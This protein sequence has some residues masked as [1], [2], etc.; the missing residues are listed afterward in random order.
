[1]P[2]PT[3]HHP[4]ARRLLPLLA[5]VT[6]I[7]AVAGCGARG[8][9]GITTL[10]F[11][12]AQD[13]GTFDRVV[14]AFEA[15]HPAIRIEQQAVPFDDL[16]ATLQSR[17]GTRDA[18]IDLYDVDEPRLAAFAA[19]GFLEPLDDLAGAAAGRIDPAALKITNYRGTQ[20]AMPRWT[21]SQL[22]YYNRA[23]LARAGITPPS[24][25]PQSPATW[26]RI[27]ADGQRA[28]AAGARYG[29]IFDQVDRYYQLQPLAASLGGGPGLTGPDLLEPDITNAAW[30][31]AFSWYHA[32]FRS[33]VAPRGINPEQT[34]SLFAAGS[35]AYFAGG[36][37]NAAAFD[38]AADV[39]YGVAPFPRFAQGRPATSTG[40]W[41]TG[42]SPF[43]AHKDAAKEFLRYM[44]VDAA[45]AGQLV[46]DNIPVQRQAFERYLS[47]L[48]DRGARYA[49]IAGIVRYALAGTS[50]SRPVT[51][52]YVDFE[53]VMNRAFADIRNG[54]DAAA[55]LGQATGEL[56][57]ALA[58]YR[59]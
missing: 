55:R 51:V 42:I 36:P 59:R 20:F 40:S 26:E 28:Q 29:L 8:P 16:N 34:P 10:T 17:L 12:N 11:V 18:D 1:M 15:A 9:S 27:T 4:G 6:L 48:R 54:T 50:V 31:Q 14:A 22:L 46:S 2:V 30:T 49:Q 19:R 33:G 3:I 24:S 41:A 58:K 52:G 35:T 25:A 37:W 23:L 21:S 47:R 56:T 44:T 38:E 13:P 32:I 43:S 39:D 7:V 53:S 5:A 45:G 57:R